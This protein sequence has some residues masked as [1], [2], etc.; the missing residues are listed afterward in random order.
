MTRLLKPLLQTASLPNLMATMQN[1]TPPPS[2]ATQLSMSTYLVPLAPALSCQLQRPNTQ[3]LLDGGDMEGVDLPGCLLPTPH[4]P[5][6]PNSSSSASP[7][8]PPGD[9]IK[10]HGHSELPSPEEGLPKGAPVLPVLHTSSSN[11][12]VFPSLQ[13]QPPLA[14]HTISP[15]LSFS[16]SLSSSP[17][18]SPCQGPHP[19]RPGTCASRGLLPPPPSQDTPPPPS[20]HCSAPPSLTSS[21]GDLR[22]R[23]SPAVP[24]VS[25]S[26]SLQPSTHSLP[27]SLD[28][29]SARRG[30]ADTQTQPWCKSQLHHREARPI[31]HPQELEMQDWGPDVEE[32]KTSTEHISFIDEEEPVL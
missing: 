8:K 19:S 31:S 25:P 18:L 28:F 9:S 7:S 32:G 14:S 1:V 15:S 26:A 27:L 6:R 2:S 22:L 4:S 20:C 16:M 10:V 3:S 13:D 21:L 17:S 11:G 5:E 29:V 23:P 12:I 24:L 30:Q